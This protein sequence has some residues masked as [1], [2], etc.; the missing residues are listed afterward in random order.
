MSVPVGLKA[1]K[2][3]TLVD[4]GV[5]I[6]RIGKAAPRII[7]KLVAA[8]DQGDVR[9][10]Q[11]LLGKVLPDLK[12]VDVSQSG[13][14]FKLVINQRVYMGKSGNS[15]TV[16]LPNITVN[17]GHAESAAPVP[18]IDVTP[19]KEEPA[20]ETDFAARRKEGKIE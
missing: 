8:A 1:G 7:D 12:A 15:D 4:R 3:A 14:T 20:S 13:E 9:S 18:V 19:E 16:S 6:E 2:L 10:A 11:I 17:I 5:L